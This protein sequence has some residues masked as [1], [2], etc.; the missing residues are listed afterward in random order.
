MRKWTTELDI[1][2]KVL[3]VTARQ[4]L[5]TIQQSHVSLHNSD[6]CHYTRT[7]HDTAVTHNGDFQ[8]NIS[9]RAVFITLSISKMAVCCTS[10]CDRQQQQQ[11]QHVFPSDRKPDTHPTR[12]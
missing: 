1:K 5:V 7:Y 10:R 4:W 11:Q 2:Y 8:P 12:D 3:C 9:E 6:M